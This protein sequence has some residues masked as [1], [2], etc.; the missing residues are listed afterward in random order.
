MISERTWASFRLTAAEIDSTRLLDTGV[1][2]WDEEYFDQSGH[3]YLSFNASVSSL[4]ARVMVNWRCISS[5]IG[6]SVS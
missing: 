2:I 5:C 1:G 6:Q 3:L 4:S